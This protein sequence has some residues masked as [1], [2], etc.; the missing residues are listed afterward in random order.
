MIDWVGKLEERTKERDEARAEVK[1]LKELGCT[2]REH[3]GVEK[4]VAKIGLAELLLPDPELGQDVA[5]FAFIITSQKREIA[6]VKDLLHRVGGRGSTIYLDKD[7]DAA[8][9]GT[10]PTGISNGYAEKQASAKR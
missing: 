2:V 10:P 3:R 5:F 1:R 6:L 9:A 8:L 7:V 4:V